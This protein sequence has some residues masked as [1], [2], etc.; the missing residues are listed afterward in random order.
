MLEDARRR[1]LASRS[2]QTAGWSRPAVGYHAPGGEGMVSV[3]GRDQQAGWWIPPSLNEGICGT[4]DPVAPALLMADRFLGG[5]TCRPKHGRGPR[6][7]ARVV[8]ALRELIRDDSAAPVLSRPRVPGGENAW[9]DSRPGSPGRRWDRD[10]TVRRPGGPGPETLRMF[11]GGKTCGT[12]HGR[13]P[14]ADALWHSVRGSSDGL[15]APAL[16]TAD[17]FLGGKTCRSK[18]GRGHQ[19]VTCFIDPRPRVTRR[20]RGVLR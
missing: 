7:V 5:K 6:T 12:W 2:P 19:T 9:S 3:A 10:S 16:P 11:L 4:D 20:P 18:Y 15:V 1:E 8:I 13:G 17:R 14:R